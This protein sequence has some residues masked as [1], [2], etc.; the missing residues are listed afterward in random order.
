MPKENRMI[1]T[2]IVQMRAQL[3]TV[4]TLM[5]LCGITMGIAGCGGA[6]GPARYQVS[7]KVTFGGKPVPYGMVYFSP[8]ASKGNKG[9]QGV[10]QIK[11]GKYDT[12]LDGKGPVSGP[13]VVKII[14]Y[15][16]LSSDENNPSEPL[17]Q[18]WTTNIDIPENASTQ[19]FEVPADAAE[20]TESQ[21]K[22]VEA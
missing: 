15:E 16:T 6:G 21:K 17:F 4:G 9:P 18:D 7:W 20:G 8:D 5:A 13:V 22:D 2:R 19:D 3:Q 1:E 10:A 11:D 12:A 14:G